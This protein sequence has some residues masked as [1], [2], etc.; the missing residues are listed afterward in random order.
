MPKYSLKIMEKSKPECLSMGLINTVS[1]YLTDYETDFKL[2]HNFK[3]QEYWWDLV[4]RY[5]QFLFQHFQSIILKVN[6]Y[7]VKELISSIK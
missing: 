5:L 1:L 7:P 3:V 2:Y 4:S 6:S